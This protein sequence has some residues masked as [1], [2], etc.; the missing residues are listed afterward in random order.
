MG[1]GG[2]AFNTEKQITLNKGESSSIKKY[3]LRYDALSNY[4]SAQKD[5]VVATLTLFNDNHK[6]GI[7]SPEKS[8][9]KGQGQPTTEVAIHSN[10]KEDLYIIL[11]GHDKDTA[12]FK[13]LLNP[14]VIWLWIGG[15]IMALGTVIVMLPNRRKNPPHPTF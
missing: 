7:L 9:Y 4:P 5:R 15:L 2:S 1:F 10:L 12:T 3:T 8:L 13:V 11:A 6:V 14:L